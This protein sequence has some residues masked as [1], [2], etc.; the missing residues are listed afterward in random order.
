M[1]ELTLDFYDVSGGG[2]RYCW[3]FGEWSSEEYESEFLARSALRNGKLVF[4]QVD[5]YDGYEAALIGAEVN[6]SLDPP[7]DYWVI[8][9]SWVLEPDLGGK[10]LGEIGYGDF[11]VRDNAKV[12]HITQEQFNIMVNDFEDEHGYYP[13]T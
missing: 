6:F 4:S 1:T 5:R 8:A 2:T 13:D 7:F 12:L 9:A 11:K 3:K 10:Q